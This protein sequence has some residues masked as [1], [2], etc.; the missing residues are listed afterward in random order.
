MALDTIGSLLD[1]CRFWTDR[2]HQLKD[3]MKALYERC[4]SAM[5]TLGAFDLIADLQRHPCNGV[6]EISVKILERHYQ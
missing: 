1:K 5:E 6:Y 4:I 3:E 2:E